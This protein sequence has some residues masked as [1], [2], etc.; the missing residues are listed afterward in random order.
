MPH[1]Q[2]VIREEIAKS[3]AETFAFL[4]DHANIGTMLRAPIKRIKPGADSPN[5]V[6]SVRGIGYAPLLI[7]ETVTAIVPDESI[8]YRI[9][10]NGGPIRQHRGK[11]H[12]SASPHGTQVTWEIE[13]QAP[14][15]IGGLLR[16]ALQRG[17][18][19]GLRRI[20]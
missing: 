17:I 1:Y 20:P 14:P 11:M 2:L 16:K 5:G 3:P 18:G 10:R 12:F 13:Y 19:A 4:S 8:E 9:T 15:L 6:G 7:E